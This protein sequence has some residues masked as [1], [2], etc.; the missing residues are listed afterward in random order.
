MS[1]E[2]IAIHMEI[3]RDA[4]GAIVKKRDRGAGAMDD[5]EFPHR[6]A[7]GTADIGV[8]GTNDHAVLSIPF[9]RDDH[10]LITWRWQADEPPA[11][12]YPGGQNGQP[13]CEHAF[14]LQRH[15]G[16][17]CVGI[18]TGDQGEAGLPVPSV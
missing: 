15:P 12:A 9:L 17:V 5:V 10:D 8:G 18:D 14:W 7:S 6:T 1:V 11:I 4:D 16:G 13:A 2:Y 3:A